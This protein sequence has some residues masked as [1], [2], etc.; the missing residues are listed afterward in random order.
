MGLE[1]LLVSLL[2]GA[3]S[4][5]LA[6]QVMRGGGFGLIGDIVVGFVGATVANWLFP[7]LGLDMGG[8]WTGAIIPAALGAILFLGL[9]RLLGI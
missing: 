9:L 8:G 3:L 5:W 2:I 6:G 4:G 1:S 7:A